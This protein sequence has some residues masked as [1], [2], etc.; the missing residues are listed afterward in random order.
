[1][2]SSMGRGDDSFRASAARF[3]TTHWSVV[4]AAGHG[5]T[6]QSREALSTLCETYWYPLYAYV[7]RKGYD[8]DE[9]ADLTQGFFAHFLQKNYLG[10][11]RRERGRFRSYL[12][13][14]LNHF[15]VNEWERASARKRG[16]GRVLERLDLVDAEKRYHVEPSHVVTP[17]ILYERRWALTLLE[18]ALARLEEECDATEKS[19]LLR[20]LSTYFVG[21]ES[22]YGKYKRLAT[23]LEMTEGAVRVAA[24]RLRQRYGEILRGEIARTVA[25][26]EELDDEI[27]HLFSVLST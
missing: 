9:S 5:G 21:G 23:E 10:S 20:S 14:A 3:E 24:H 11:V 12:L 18:R 22:V 1:M 17:A 7:R 4:L 26:P 25:E 27:R 16:G 19:V 2:M 13:G 6:P 15:L 8:A